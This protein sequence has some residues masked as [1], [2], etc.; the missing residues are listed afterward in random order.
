MQYAVPSRGD[1]MTHV[2]PAINRTMKKDVLSQ[3]SRLTASWVNGGYLRS[4]RAD[5]LPNIDPYSGRLLGD[6]ELADAAVVDRAVEAGL[7]ALKGPWADLQADG[8][9]A[10]LRNLADAV[11]SER[12]SF[13]MLETL[14]TGKPM[15][16]SY[17]DDV[18]T[19]VGVFRWFASMAETAYD[20]SPTRRAGAM[21]R[22]AREPQGVV[23]IILPWNFP[24]TTLALKL[25]PALAAGNA[26]VCK[27]A[28]DT[29]LTSL[30]LA[31]LATEIGF[32][33]GVINV[34]TGLGHIVGKAIGLHPDVAA[35]NFTGSTE[36]GRWFLRYAA[37]SNLKEVSLECGGKNP[38]IIL[39]GQ[40]DVEPFAETLATGF[41]MNSGQLCS[42]ISRVLAPKRAERSL[43]D[44]LSAQMDAWAV[45]DPFDARTRIGPMI[46]R[47]HADKV[48]AAIAAERAVNNDVLVSRADSTGTCERL[49][50]P[51][52]F[53]D[54]DSDGPTWKDEIFGPV[55]AVRFYDEIEQAIESANAT[56]FGLS[57]YLFGNDPKTIESVA[58]RLDTGF[59]AVN[60]FSEGDFTTP[61]GGFK[62]SGFGGKDKGIHALDQYSR[63][64]SIWWQLQP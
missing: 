55:L 35:I 21:A 3:A 17:N 34:V 32:P 60:A 26:V 48:Q 50:T 27:P 49:V 18:P 63:V 31:E 52:V 44:S 8:R 11:E 58:R 16:H 38:A 62:Q 41:L 19:A 51:T 56:E 42:S 37:D 64:K 29:P 39:P 7:R 15:Q 12:L 25:A 30:R 53:F 61:F 23:G 47:E 14:D 57:A 36:T 40:S 2:F 22:I 24:L 5:A 10:L 20:L 4:K 28:E 9:A 59:V 45:G 46:N 6:T 13:A 43:R 1:S 33:A 54:V